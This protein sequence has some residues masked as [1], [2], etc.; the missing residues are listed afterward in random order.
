MTQI[1]R[2]TPRY[3][4]LPGLPGREDEHHAWDV[5]GRDDD[6]GAM[7]LIGPEQRAYAASLVRTGHMIPLTLPLD[8][9]DPGLFFTR[10]PYVHT[11][12][13]TKNGH[14]DKIDN[15]FLQ[16]SSQ[17]DGLRHVRCGRHGYWGGRQEEDLE[18]DGV[19]GMDRWANHGI[20]G[21]GVLIDVARH[22]AGRG[23]PLM[24]TDAFEITGELIEEI[25]DAQR[26]RFRSGDLLVLRTGWMEWYRALPAADRASMRGTV[27][28]G[29]SCPGLESSTATAAW[30]WDH[31]FAAIAA[32]NLAVEVLP[33]DRTKGFLHK[34]LIPL[35]G[36]ALGELWYLQRL[37]DFC[38][39]EGR[40][41]FLLVSGALMIPR[42]VGSPA[43][44]YALV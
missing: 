12:E 27:G 7:N 29:F 5:W 32:D 40:Y 9:P 44:A 22:M 23:S 3:A 13:T 30:L 1:T 25:A 14:D 10:D 41:E 34:R 20:G 15:F 16:Y 4:D 38:A 11:V 36:M 39:A 6:L 18:R 43:N 24:P 19:L 31:E 21:R 42:G 8:E 35:Q 28:H 17:W 2:S 37:A 26:V 33:V